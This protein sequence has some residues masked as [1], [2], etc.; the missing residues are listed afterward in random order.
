MSGLG[1]AASRQHTSGCNKKY[2]EMWGLRRTELRLLFRV[3]EDKG[4][5]GVGK[6]W[7]GEEAVGKSIFWGG[8]T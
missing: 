5:G 6:G 7:V 1:K 4:Q 3:K 8:R 2:I